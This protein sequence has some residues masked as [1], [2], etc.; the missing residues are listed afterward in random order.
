MRFVLDRSFLHDSFRTDYPPNQSAKWLFPYLVHRVAQAR[1]KICVISSTAIDRWSRE[2]RETGLTPKVVLA[3]EGIA[4]IQSLANNTLRLDDSTL[5]VAKL[6]HDRGMIP[7]ILSSVK[8]DKW[9]ER[10][11]KLG[12]KLGLEEFT[13]EMSKK[14]IDQQMWSA[15]LS[16]EFCVSIMKAYDPF[17]GRI[18]KI[19]DYPKE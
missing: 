12:I 15:P 1:L 2:F 16:A 8:L 17:F 11:Q 4:H 10:T 14:R 18:V 7:I 13:P 5:I 19:I 3:V 6:L 9:K